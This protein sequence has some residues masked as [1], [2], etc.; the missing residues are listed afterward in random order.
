MIFPKVGLGIHPIVRFRQLLILT[1]GLRFFL[2]NAML[3]PDVLDKVVYGLA[4]Y[5]GQFAKLFFQPVFYL[6]CRQVGVRF[7]Q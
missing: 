1:G 4:M 7:Q 3:P 6:S 5:L 2:A